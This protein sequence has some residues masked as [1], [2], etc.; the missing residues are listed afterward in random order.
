MQGLKLCVWVIFIFRQSHQVVGGH[1]VK[2]CQG[3][4]GKGADVLIVLVLIF[5]Q[6][7]LGKAGLFGQLLQSEVLVYYPQVF[8]AFCDSQFDIHP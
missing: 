7:G 6:C 3:C 2:L 1:P 8:Q 4:N 5:A